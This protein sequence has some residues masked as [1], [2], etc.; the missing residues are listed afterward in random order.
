MSASP[1]SMQHYSQ[2]PTYGNN[3]SNSKWMDKDDVTHIYVCL[4]KCVHIYTSPYT[5][6]QTQ[7]YYSVTRKM[8]V[9]MFLTIRMNLEG[10]ILSKVSWANTAFYHLHVE[11]KKAKLRE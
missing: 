9:L 7:Q 1:Y 11:S 10:I 3:V 8:E 2:E 4:Y 6:T 5:H